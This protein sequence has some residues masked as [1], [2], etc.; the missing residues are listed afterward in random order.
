MAPFKDV[1]SSETQEFLLLFFEKEQTVP[2]KNA[3][4]EVWGQE[5]SG[6]LYKYTVWI[7]M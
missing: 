1:G 2:V 7:K 5:V 6:N 3:H 4:K